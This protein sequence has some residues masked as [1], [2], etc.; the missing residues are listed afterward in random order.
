MENNKPEWLLK[1]EQE[2]SKFNK[3]EW[4]KLTEKEFIFK[5]KQQHAGKAGGKKALDSGQFKER[6]RL[7]AIGSNK[8]KRYLTFDQAEEVR[9]KYKTGNYSW[10]SLGKEYG[11]PKCSIGRIIKNK[12]Y[13]ER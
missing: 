7:G 6:A 12:T 9:T 1:A 3:S 10:S 5:E 2:Q 4:G 13:T 8:L 11:L